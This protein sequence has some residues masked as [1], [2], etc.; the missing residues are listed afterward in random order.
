MIYSGF[1]RRFVAFIIDMLIV[2]IPTALL[3]IP[4]L[5][6][7]L[8]GVETP[9][10]LSQM[11]LGF[12]GL[13]FISWQFFSLLITWLYFAILESGAK[14]ATW[15][16][17]LLGIKVI[18]T[19][20][21]RMSFGRATG[22]F[23]SKSLSYAIVW[24]GFIMAGFTSRKRALHDMIAGTYVVKKSFEPGQELPETKSRKFLFVI[25]CV[26]WVLFLLGITA[27]SNIM[28]MSPTQQAA[29]LAAQRLVNLTNQR[30]ALKEP[31]RLETSTFYQTADGYRAVVV[32]PQTD[33]KFTLF[34]QNSSGQVCCQAFPFGDCQDTGFEP[35]EN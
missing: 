24:I 13:T 15:G 23:F 26:L 31:L 21:E 35:C 19:T 32:D 6:T 14:Q 10:Q 1:W 9:D 3:F 30:M 4:V 18:T 11:Q 33:N 8:A 2:S 25:A 16:K 12:L 5:G 22:R 20:G 29:Q 28:A 17:R 7:Q 27:L 34:L